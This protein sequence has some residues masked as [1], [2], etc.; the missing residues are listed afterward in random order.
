M[1]AIYLE[2]SDGREHKFYEAST[3]GQVL[4]V[5]Y[6]RIGTAGQNQTKTF[7]TLQAAEAEAYKKLA[8]KRKKG[9]AEA[10]AGQTEKKA[11]QPTRLKLPKLLRPYR[12][13]IEATLQP[14]VELSL[15][16]EPMSAWSSKIGGVPY[17]PNSEVWPLDPAGSPLSFLAQLNFAELPAL[18]DFP[19][20]GLVQFFIGTDDTMGC[21]FAGADQPQDTYRVLYFENVVQDESQLDASLPTW[22][23]GA[24]WNSPL[25]KDKT[26]KVTGKLV[27]MPI[28][29]RDRSFEAQVDIDFL[30][31][32]ASPNEDLQL[33]EYLEEQYRDMSEVGHQLGGYPIF[34]QED[35]RTPEQPH[36]LL[37]QLDSDWQHNILWGDVGIGNFFIDPADLVRRNFSKVFY[38]WDCG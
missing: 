23:E 2:L 36:I 35:P 7:E 30:D 37:F 31:A 9:Y 12:Q 28:T 13:Q 29:A 24:Y 22:P 21:R 14:V 17:R 10:I 25:P 3:Q 26:F 34:T 1:E 6:G 15:S 27:E 33:G 4:S 38:N 32:S 16:E 8:E 18:E 20:V 5:R 11:P 19:T